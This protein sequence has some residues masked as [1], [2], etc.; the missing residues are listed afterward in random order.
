MKNIY[1]S[2]ALSSLVLTAGAQAQRLCLA[3]EFTQAS[4]GPCA[5]ANPAFNSMLNSNASKIVPIKYQVNWPGVDPMNAQYPTGPSARVSY[6]G[7]N[8]VPYALMDGVA[9]TGSSYTGYPGNLTSSEINTEYNTASPFYLDVSHYL[10]AAQDSV[11][12]TI[13]LMA[14]QQFTSV[15][16]LRLQTVLIEKHIHFTSPPGSNG[17][18][19]FYNVCRKMI[20]T[21]GGMALPATWNSGDDSVITLKTSIP[22]YIYDINELAVVCFIQ[23]NGNKEVKQAAFSSSPVGIQT[24]GGAPSAINLFPNPAKDNVKLDFVLEHTSDVTVNIYN[25]SGQM[26]SSVNHGNYAAGKQEIEVNIE[27]LASGIYTVEL[28]ADDSRTTSRLN[29]VH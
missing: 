20:P 11:F 19:D 8:S 29:V 25:V 26:V 4:C 3:E 22:T 28:V 13:H 27:T 23:D 24:F 1:L 15:G 5:A 2:I 12:I 17:E 6:Y 10:N 7:L 21:V 18:A 16:Y 14:A 9:A